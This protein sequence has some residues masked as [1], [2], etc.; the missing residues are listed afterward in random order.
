MACTW[1]SLRLLLAFPLYFPRVSAHKTSFCC[2]GR[3]PSNAFFQ[4][5][6]RKFRQK[7]ARNAGKVAGQALTGA[8]SA[9][10]LLYIFYVYRIYTKGNTLYLN[11][12]PLF[13]GHIYPYNNMDHGDHSKHTM[14]DM[15]MPACSVGCLCLYSQNTPCQAKSA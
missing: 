1:L 4:N 9:V 14:P 6:Q 11:K 8:R 3:Q 10:C 13:P 7:T 15:D 2:V 12:D 5:S